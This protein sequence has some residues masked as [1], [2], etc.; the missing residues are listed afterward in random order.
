MVVIWGIRK[1]ECKIQSVKFK[2]Q[3]AG[4]QNCG[5]ISINKNNR[6]NDINPIGTWRAMSLQVTA[7]K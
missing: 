4:I 3:N 1:S 7:T 5:R 2:I 6:I